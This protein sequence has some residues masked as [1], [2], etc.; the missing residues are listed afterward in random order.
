MA[1]L[2]LDLSG[3]Y[4]TTLSGNKYIV[5]FVD[6]YSGWPEAFSVPDKTASSIAYL[7]VEEIFRRYGCPLQTVTDNRT[8]NINKTVLETLQSLK[9]DHIRTSVYHPQSNARVERFHRTLHDI[10][11]KKTQESQN[12]WDLFLNQTLA[13]VRFNISQS[14]KYSPFFLLYNR[15]VVLPVDN[16]LKPRRKYVGEEMHL[17]ALQE[18]HKSLV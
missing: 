12:T 17:I 2:S 7:I 11:A 18:Q 10:L 13:A 1:K 6:W 4:H 3:P 8:E 16:L 5:A 9:I 15:D 14:S